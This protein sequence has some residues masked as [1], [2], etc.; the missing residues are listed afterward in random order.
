[1][2]GGSSAVVIVVV[3]VFVID[4]CIIAFPLNSA[5]DEKVEKEQVDEEA[6]L[7]EDEEGIVCKSER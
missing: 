5:D 4:W 1:V 6:L 2:G 7:P 3:V